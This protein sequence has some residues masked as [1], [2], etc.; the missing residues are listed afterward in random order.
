MRLS[1]KNR[2]IP[3]EEG[4]RLGQQLEAE[5]EARLKGDQTLEEATA[6]ETSSATRKSCCLP[7]CMDV[8]HEAPPPLYS[9]QWAH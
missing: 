3:C 9:K 8:E 4:S 5:V 7:S 1:G 2:E 6:D